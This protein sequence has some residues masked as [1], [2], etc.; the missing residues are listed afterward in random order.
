MGIK[1]EALIADR[2]V[3]QTIILNTYD[4]IKMK[5]KCLLV[6]VAFDRHH[7]ISSF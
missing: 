7:H 6:I 1:N 5:R 4:N 2:K 3:E